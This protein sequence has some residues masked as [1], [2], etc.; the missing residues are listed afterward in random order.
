MK[1]IVLGVDGSHGSRVATAWCARF[2]HSEGAQVV[3]VHAVPWT[4]PAAERP[5]IEDALVRQ[6]CQPLVEEGVDTKTLVLD[7]DPAAALLTVADDCDADLIV[8]GRRGTGGF[9]ELLLG[10]VPSRL[11]LYAHRPLV[12]VPEES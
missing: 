1:H 9:E 10:S 12:I 2:A 4:V 11:V 5:A 8:V 7:A 3:A 6:W